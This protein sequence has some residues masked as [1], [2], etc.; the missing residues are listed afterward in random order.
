MIPIRVRLGAY[1]PD[2]VSVKPGRLE[3]LSWPEHLRPDEEPVAIP[4]RAARRRARKR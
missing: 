3:S 4:N 1:A 2:Q